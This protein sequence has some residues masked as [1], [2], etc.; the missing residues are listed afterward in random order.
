MKKQ[1]LILVCF[2]SLSMLGFRTVYEM[3]DDPGL[4]AETASDNPLN[5][6]GKRN[7]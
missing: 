3:L 6:F 5:D 1:V 4:T 7:Q 2:L